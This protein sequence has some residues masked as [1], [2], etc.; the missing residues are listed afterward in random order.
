M[1]S[2]DLT[3]KKIRNT[4]QRLTQISGSQLVDGTGSLIDNIT[5]TGSFKGDGSGLTNIPPSGINGYQDRIESGLSRAFISEESEVGFQVLN[6]DATFNE[7]AF[8]KKNVT[9]DENLTAPRFEGGLGDGGIQVLNSSALLFTRGFK[10]QTS[11]SLGLGPAGFVIYSGSAT[12]QLGADTLQGTGFK[13]VGTDNSS[14]ISFSDQNGG[15][16]EIRTDKFTLQNS[17]DITA[18]NA[19]FSGTA[20]A[21]NFIQKSVILSGSDINGSPFDSYLSEG[22]D[23]YSLYLDGTLGGEIINNVEF[24]LPFSGLSLSDIVVKDETSLTND[25][26]TI[27]IRN[28]NDSIGSI[29]FEIRLP[30]DSQFFQTLSPNNIY[31]FE[32]SFDNE[33]QKTITPIAAT[34]LSIPVTASED[35]YRI[36]GD[37][38]ATNFYGTASYASYAVSAS[39]EIIKEVSSSFADTASYVNPLNQDV[40]ITGNVGIGTS[41]PT[42]TLDVRGTISQTVDGSTNEYPIALYNDHSGTDYYLLRQRVVGSGNTVRTGIGITGVPSTAFVLGPQTDQT[43]TFNSAGI[44]TNLAT[45]NGTNP[46]KIN[47]TEIRVGDTSG[48]VSSTFNI[49]G[50]NDK[51]PLGIKQESG[52]T[53]N[54]FVTFLDSGS[55]EVLGITIDGG[56]TAT[57]SNLIKRFSFGHGYT[58][59][60]TDGMGIGLDLKTENASGTVVSVGSIDVVQDD[61]SA[62]ESSMRLSVGETTPTEIMRLQSD[63][64]VGIGTTSPQAKLHVS[65]TVQF[66]DILSVTPQD[67]LPS[68]VP[69]GS[70]AVSSSAPPKPYFYDGTNWNALY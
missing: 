53:Q 42:A 44:I 55:T 51:V 8:F 54:R 39:H 60:A 27:S 6:A 62:D 29:S 10:G 14:S 11:A 66:D 46:L 18:S 26:I 15:D 47:S 70:F 28:R 2:F 7:D 58:P 38:Y 9:I 34:D 25:K 50:D 49:V 41:S 61:V 48:T 17:G 65:G 35:G 36:K 19:L 21:R 5:I 67:P 56:F 20:I 33:G 59:S 69:T 3:G 45:I 52:T 57:D 13:F 30:N 43:I 16:L 4:Y 68:G 23:G 31:T 37:V 40:Q 1:S 32:I 63:G 12:T 24:A 22:E 64:N